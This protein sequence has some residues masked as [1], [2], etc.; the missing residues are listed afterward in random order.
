MALTLILSLLL[1]L[2]LYLLTVP[3]IF[4]INTNTQEYSVR[5]VGLAKATLEG[6]KNELLRIKLKVPFKNFY[7]YPFRTKTK[8]KEKKRKAAKITKRGKKFKYKSFVRV[9]NSFKLK[10]LVLNMDTGDYILN[11]KLYPVFLALN[12]TKGNFNINFEGKNELIVCIQNRP[13]NII[14]SFINI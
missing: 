9:L 12:Y 2:I 8:T 10:Q 5:V 11:A 1:L 4:L 13:V 7:F 14:R 3:V 6:D